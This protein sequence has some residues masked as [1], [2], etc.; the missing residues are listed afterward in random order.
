MYYGY[1]VFKTGHF[2]YL[3]VIPIPL[4][5]TQDTPPPPPSVSNTAALTSFARAQLG[6]DMKNLH[7]LA[8]SQTTGAQHDGES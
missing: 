7:Y 3:E 6:A 8:G 2:R 1:Y 5:Y 4:E